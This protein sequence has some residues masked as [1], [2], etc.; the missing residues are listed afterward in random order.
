ML[1]FHPGQIVKLLSGGP[2]MT[3]EEF[4][5][6]PNGTSRY[7]CVWFDTLGVLHSQVISERLLTSA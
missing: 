2:S 4:V 6:A 3:V 5:D 7:R 1:R